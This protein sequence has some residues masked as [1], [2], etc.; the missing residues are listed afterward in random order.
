MLHVLQGLEQRAARYGPPRYVL[1][2]SIRAKVVDELLLKQ[3]TAPKAFEAAEPN[4]VAEGGQTAL[5]AHST[6]LKQQVVHILS[7]SYAALKFMS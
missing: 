4:M 6:D 2:A 7:R 3:L 5:N 1:L